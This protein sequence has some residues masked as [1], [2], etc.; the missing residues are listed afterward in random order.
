MKKKELY[1]LSIGFSPLDN[2]SFSLFVFKIFFIVFSFQKFNYSVV[3]VDLFG[4]MLSGFLE[5]AGF[6]YF[7]HISLSWGI[8]LVL[9]PI[10]LLSLFPARWVWTFSSLLIPGVR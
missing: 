5:S 6:H 3:A 8:G 1:C 10:P 7:L 4:F 2:V 9:L